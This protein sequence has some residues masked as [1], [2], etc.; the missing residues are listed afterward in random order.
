MSYYFY[1]FAVTIFQDIII[2]V[3]YISNLY[4]MIVQVYYGFCL[5]RLRNSSHAINKATNSQEI[6]AKT[7]KVFYLCCVIFLSNPRIAPC[8]GRR[9]DMYVSHILFHRI[10]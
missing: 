5:L 2:L 4:F 8:L 6:F 1:Y 3:Y 10:S 7:G 9:S